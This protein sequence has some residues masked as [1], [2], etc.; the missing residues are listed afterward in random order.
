MA[1]VL[2]AALIGLAT[3]TA[4][5][6]TKVITEDITMPPSA[7]ETRIDDTEPTR[8]TTAEPIE[9]TSDSLTVEDDDPTVIYDLDRLPAEV[10]QT[11]DALVAAALG[12]DVEA[13]RP[14]LDRFV[15]APIVTFG[16]QTDVV[17]DLLAQSG[18]ANGQEILAILL[19]VLRAGYVHMDAGTPQEAYVWPY[20]AHTRLDNLTPRQRVELFTLVTAHDYDEMRNF[21]AYIFYRAGIGPDGDWLFFVAGD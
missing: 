10:R 3:Q 17:E 16:E 13:L 4:M 15:D 14:I 12:G 2:L 1:A 11:H 19:E 8:E 9:G 6:T 21:G 18:D 20:F 7:G 5:A